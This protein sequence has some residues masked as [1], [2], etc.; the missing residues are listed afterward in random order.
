MPSTLL[1]IW[2]YGG[3]ALIGLLGGL[4]LKHGTAGTI[5]D[6]ILGGLLG[7]VLYFF[8]SVFYVFGPDESQAASLFL[9]ILSY[10]GPAFGGLLALWLGR[11][12]PGR[13]GA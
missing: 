7:I 4:I 10:S 13:S 5:V 12:L 6:M 8:A 9:V 11:L 1:A 2:I 3:G